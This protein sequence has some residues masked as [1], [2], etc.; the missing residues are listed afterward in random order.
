MEEVKLQYKDSLFC[1][2][3]KNPDRLRELYGA[4]T[5]ITLP[6]DTPVDVNSLDNVLLQGFI[7]DISFVIGGRLV[8]LVEH[9]S[10]INP[11]M[12]LRFLMYITQLYEKM[13]EHKKLF[14]SKLIHIPRP[15]FFVLYNGTAPFPDK[16]TLRL[17]D[18]FLDAEAPG[19]EK[20]E[21][22]L[23]LIAHIFNINEGRNAEIVS[24]CK[25]LNDYSAFV[26]LERFFTQQSGDRV[27]AMKNA[28][29]YCLEHGILKEYMERHAEEVLNMRITDWNLEDALAVTREEALEDGFE[30]GL[31][32]GR[33]EKR[34]IA[35]RL[36][37]MGLSDEQ[38]AEAT[39]LPQDMPG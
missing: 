38:I 36:K 24:K 21:I 31:E 8:V 28:V 14:S 13:H 4:L 30:R 20:Q 6:P 39:G 2:L 34:E 18:A 10:T 25:T 1:R 3:F 16:Q 5:G 12:G 7:N 29:Q 15:E 33:A 22:S 11:N 35:R 19:M 9:Q 27:E 17:S 37:A 26:A 23:E 32:R